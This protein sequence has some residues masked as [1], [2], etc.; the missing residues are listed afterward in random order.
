MFRHST[1]FRQAIKCP[2]SVFANP[3]AF[4]LHSYQRTTIIFLSIVSSSSSSSLNGHR[5]IIH[6]FILRLPSGSGS[7]SDSDSDS[8]ALQNTFHGNKSPPPST[9]Y[10]DQLGRMFV[11]TQ[12]KIF[13]YSRKRV[14]RSA[15][16]SFVLDLDLC[17]PW[18]FDWLKMVM[19]TDARW[20]TWRLGLRFRR[21]GTVN[22][23][24]DLPPTRKHNIRRHKTDVMWLFLWRL[25]R[26]KHSQ[27]LLIILILTFVNIFPTFPCTIRM[28]FLF[29][30]CET[31]DN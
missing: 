25:G 8:I 26:V 28:L 11:W 4:K 22:S 23:T 19:R 1:F 29:L 2:V 7:G 15:C 31:C 18:C 10:I 17:S 13:N 14:Y 3:G 20:R 6:I 16:L 5:I 24:A 27:T 12:P 30:N 9:T 21:W